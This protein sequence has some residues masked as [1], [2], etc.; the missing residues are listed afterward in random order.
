MIDPRFANT[1]AVPLGPGYGVQQA[2]T[3]YHRHHRHHKHKVRSDASPVSLDESIHKVDHSQPQYFQNNVAAQGAGYGVPYGAGA[4]AYP[5]QPYGAGNYGY[6]NQYQGPSYGVPPGAIGKHHRHHHRHHHHHG[7]DAAGFIDHTHIVP[8]QLIGQRSSSALGYNEHALGAVAIH[9]GFGRSRPS[10]RRRHHRHHHHHHSGDHGGFGHTH[11]SRASRYHSS[12]G[13]GGY[14]LLKDD[15]IFIERG[16]YSPHRQ[17]PPEGYEYKGKIEVQNFDREMILQG[18][19]QVVV[20]RP[21][22]SVGP[23]PPGWQPVILPGGSCGPCPSGG[24]AYP[25]QLVSCGAYSQGGVGG[26]GAGGYGAGGYGASGYGGGSGQIVADYIFGSGSGGAFPYGRS[27][28][29]G[30][31][32]EGRVTTRATV[33]EV[34]Q[35]R[36]KSELRERSRSR[37][38]ERSRGPDFDF[39]RLRAEILLAIERGLPRNGTSPIPYPVAPQIIERVK[40]AGEVRVIVQPI[41]PVFYMPRQNDATPLG[42][43]IGPIPLG[44]VP[45]ASAPQIVYVPRNVYVPVIKPV[46]VPRE[47][48]IVRP[49]VIHVARP[50]LVDRPVPVTQRPIIIDRERPIPVPVRSAPQGVPGGSRVVREEY[51]YRDNLPVAYG[52]RCAEFAGGVNYGYM[53]TQ[54]EHQ[55]ANSSTHETGSLYHAQGQNINLNIPTHVQQS[56]TSSFVEGYGGPGSYNGSYSNLAEVGNI[57]GGVVNVGPLNQNVLQQTFEQSAHVAGIPHYGAPQVEILDTAVNPHWQRTDQSSLMRRYGR[58]AHE[59]VNQSREVEQQMYNEIN[60]QPHNVG[61]VQSASNVSFEA[62]PGLGVG[63][64]YGEF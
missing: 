24:T 19:T 50:V 48:I 42:P 15:L 39:E 11:Q 57:G 2:P 29:G 31:L 5:Q 53:P 38:R 34:W 4:G 54:R 1:G 9:D 62:G 36:G 25:G 18:Q 52:G 16:D 6:G 63:C 60:H 14:G 3:Q 46:F 22:P 23:C 10:R 40:E 44:P 7:G 32:R 47:R 58:P 59:I 56:Q 41:Q 55:Y 61:M 45:V 27:T 21:P 33:I 51:V 37:S 64:D 20:P 8:E 17:E 26:Y 35:R 43:H 28:S 13:V 12:A 30:K 49:Q